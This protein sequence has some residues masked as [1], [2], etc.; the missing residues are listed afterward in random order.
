MMKIAAFKLF[1]LLPKIPKRFSIYTHVFTD[2]Q[3]LHVSFSIQYFINSKINEYRETTTLKLPNDSSWLVRGQVL[4]V[5][6]DIK[7]TPVK[8][9]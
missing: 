1:E 8:I 3:D 6:K 4:H 5:K 9:K 2:H 7:K